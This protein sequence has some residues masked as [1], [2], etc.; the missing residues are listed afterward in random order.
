MHWKCAPSWHKLAERPTSVAVLNRMP[1]WSARAWH[2]N[3]TTPAGN[4]RT[5]DVVL[6][7]PSRFLPRFIAI[8]RQLEPGEEDWLPLGL[9]EIADHMQKLPP[10]PEPPPPIETLEHAQFDSDSQKQWNPFYRLSAH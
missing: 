2:E 5:N 10:A 9:H 7:L 8:L 6:F 3:A 1:F 4:P